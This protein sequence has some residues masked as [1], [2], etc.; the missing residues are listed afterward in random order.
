MNG[1]SLTG[2]GNQTV[3]P[4]SLLTLLERFTCLLVRLWASSVHASVSDDERQAQVYNWLELNN[5][6]SAE[7]LMFQCER[8]GGTEFLVFPPTFMTDRRTGVVAL[9]ALG[10]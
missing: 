4:F 10:P 8:M 3:S 1:G 6:S 9:V 5:L 7:F 2:S